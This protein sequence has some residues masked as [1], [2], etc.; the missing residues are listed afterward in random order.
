MQ[1]IIPGTYPHQNAI[2]SALLGFQNSTNHHQGGNLNLTGVLS[3][4][5]TSDKYSVMLPVGGDKY[6]ILG[7]GSQLAS[8]NSSPVK[9]SQLQQAIQ[10]HLLGSN[11]SPYTT[12]ALAAVAASLDSAAGE[13]PPSYGS[14]SSARVA[15]DGSSTTLHGNARSGAAVAS[16][17]ST[18]G[19]VYLKQLQD[20]QPGSY[21]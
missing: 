20:A 4:G 3:S 9:S 12:A 13:P 14:S 19:D 5:S 16:Q 8:S 10:R 15:S 6:S 21:N 11:S 7:G 18:A 2:P 1:H 17:T